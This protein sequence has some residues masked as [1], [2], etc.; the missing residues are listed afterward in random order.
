MYLQNL[1]VVLE[2]VSYKDG[3]VVDE[4]LQLLLNVRE[5]YGHAPESL[6][7]HSRV[8]SQI[9]RNWIGRQDQFVIDDLPVLADKRDARKL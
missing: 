9:V 8:F 7:G 5:S 2:R 6:L 3:V 4:F 1:H